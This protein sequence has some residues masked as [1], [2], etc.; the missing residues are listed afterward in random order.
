MSEP[1]KPHVFVEGQ[2]VELRTNRLAGFRA[3]I[4]YD[5]AQ[6]E[7]HILTAE[8][9]SVDQGIP[10]AVRLELGLLIDALQVA[11]SS[12]NIS[13]GQAPHT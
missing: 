4:H 6:V 1:K 9:R 10:E 7:L 13:L 11:M 3:K 2:H 5:R 12:S 8:P